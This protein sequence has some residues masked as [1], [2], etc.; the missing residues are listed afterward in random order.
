METTIKTFDAVVE[1][2]KWREATSRKLD[3]MSLEERL[4]HLRRKK[5]EYL[6]AQANREPAS[7][8]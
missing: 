7:P 6:A 2:Q 3:A 5:D 4:R 1:S 8:R